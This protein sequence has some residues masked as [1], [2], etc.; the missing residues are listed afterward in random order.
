VTDG[1]VFALDAANSRCYSGSGITFDGLIGGIGGTLVNGVGFSSANN[2]SFFFDGTNDYIVSPSDSSY[3]FGANDFTVSAWFK[4]SDKSRYSNIFNLYENNNFGIELYS[5]LT[6]GYFRTWV[7]STLL[8]GDID[9]TNNTWNHVCL[10]RLSGTITQFVNGIQNLSTTATSS[11]P[12]NILKIGSIVNA[13]Y[14]LGNISQVSMYNRALTA[15]EI[16]QNFNAMKGRY[17]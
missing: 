1:L 2:G 12:L 13:Y 15:Q 5:N 7:G 11:I 4:S 9:I 3:A 6:N 10:R 16:L 14:C 17:R 8:V